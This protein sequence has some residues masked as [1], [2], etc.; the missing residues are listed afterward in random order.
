M[1]IMLRKLHLQCNW[2]GRH[3]KLGQNTIL[4]HNLS[5][6]E[7]LAAHMQQSVGLYIGRYVERVCLQM[8]LAAT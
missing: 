5:V 6:R 3:T 1:T 7:V 4:Q 8:K 2:Q